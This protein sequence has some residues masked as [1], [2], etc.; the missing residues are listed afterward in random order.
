[1]GPLYGDNLIMITN[2]KAFTKSEVLDIRRMLKNKTVTQTVAA[3]LFGVSRKTIYNLFTNKLYRDVPNPRQV[4]E[5]KNYEIYPD[6]RVW[7]INKGQFV[8]QSFSKLNRV[9]KISR[10]DGKR[11]TVPVAS[12]IAKAFKVKKG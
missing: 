6:G 9:V 7:S 1:M 4:K 2:V 12:L 10:T 11:V 5:F 8:A 3:Q